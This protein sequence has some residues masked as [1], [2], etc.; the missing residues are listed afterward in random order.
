MFIKE[1]SREM[2]R[3]AAEIEKKEGGYCWSGF[4]KGNLCLLQVVLRGE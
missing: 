4:T 1:N 2:E 3:Q